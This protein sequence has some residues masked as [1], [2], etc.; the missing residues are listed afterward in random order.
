[1]RVQSLDGEDS[2]GVG[3]GNPLQYSCLENPTEKPGGRLQSMGSQR[4]GH[5][6]ATEN[7]FLSVVHEHISLKLMRNLHVILTISSLPLPTIKARMEKCSLPSPGSQC[8]RRKTEKEMKWLFFGMRDGFAWWEAHWKDSKGNRAGSPL[9]RRTYRNGPVHLLPTSLG[10][11]NSFERGSSVTPTKAQILALIFGSLWLC[12][13]Q[14][15]HIAFHKLIYSQNVFHTL[16]FS[17]EPLIM[18][19]PHRAGEIRKSG[20]KHEYCP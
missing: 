6:W 9:Y 14:T 8:Q 10:D 4:V 19:E 16:S 11:S 2:P 1:M 5:N 15:D 13:T 18:L 7:T 12:P 17:T 3:N 20:N